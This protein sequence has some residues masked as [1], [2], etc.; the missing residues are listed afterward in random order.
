[1]ARERAAI[2]KPVGIRVWKG[3]AGTVHPQIVELERA[4]E[5]STQLETRTDRRER[6]T[7]AQS[8]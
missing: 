6:A 1:M 8:H 2:L 4:R 5:T 3:R 7:L